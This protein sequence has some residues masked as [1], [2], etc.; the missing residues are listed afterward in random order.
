MIRGLIPLLLLCFLPSFSAAQDYV[1]PPLFDTPSYSP[2]SPVITPAPVIPV[3]EPRTAPV[4][5]KPRQKPAFKTK[6]KQEPI[7]EPLAKRDIP[8]PPKSTPTPV[9]T[10]IINKGV[11]KGPKTMPSAPA[12]AVQK[13]VLFKP[14]ARTAPLLQRQPEKTVE[15]VKKPEFI[16]PLPAFK[17][18]SEGA[19]Q[20][21]LYFVSHTE[22]L[23]A[24]N[25]ATIKHLVLPELAKN[26]D[27]RLLIQAYASPQE[28]VL[29]GDRRISLTRALNIRRMLIELGVKPSRL[30]V[31]ALGAQTNT[32][33]LD[34]V[35]LVIS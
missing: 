18:L 16:P 32:Q 7:V 25:E 30:D 31:R 20:S 10:P 8:P 19:L 6:P 15:T 27:K 12:K 24:T 35:E 9:I 13:E 23:S 17:T 2:P 3:E 26:Q 21:T 29:N 14:E 28:N 11:V 22:K 5:P 33:P 34:R 1:P 4:A